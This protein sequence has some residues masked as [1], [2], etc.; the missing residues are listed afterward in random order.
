MQTVVSERIFLKWSIV[1][2]YTPLFSSFIQCMLCR[3]ILI[4]VEIYHLVRNCL[5]PQTNF[6]AS[7]NCQIN[8][9]FTGVI[10]LPTQTMHCKEEIPENYDPFALFDPPKWVLY[11]N[12]SCFKYCSNLFFAL[13]FCPAGIAPLK[14]LRLYCLP[15]PPV[16]L[17]F[18]S[19][20]HV[21]GG[22]SKI[23][24]FSHP[25]LLE[26][27]QIYQHVFQLGWFNQQLVCLWRNSQALY[28]NAQA[29]CRKSV[30]QL[31]SLKLT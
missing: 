12:D 31:P 27:I 8:T 6:T 15:A 16:L 3:V 26:M 1:F 22:G 14:V 23:F 10:I 20:C 19:S 7:G 11:F 2:F 29:E 25:K 30:H 9:N 5:N 28:E 17:L 4:E 13:A 21:L 24:V 18:A